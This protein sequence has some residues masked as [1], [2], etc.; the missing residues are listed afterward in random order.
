METPPGGGGSVD[1][2]KKVAGYTAPCLEPHTAICET[3]FNSDFL[4]NT[5]NPRREPRPHELLLL[6]RELLNNHNS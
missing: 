4:A 3:S 6:N 1:I 5:K 2:P